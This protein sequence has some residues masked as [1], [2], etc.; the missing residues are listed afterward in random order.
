MLINKTRATAL[1]DFLQ[2]RR[3]ANLQSLLAR[4]S[5]RSIDLLNYEDVRRALKV[6]TRVDRGLQEIELDAIIGS[7]GRY[8]DF[9]RTFLPRSDSSKERWATVRQIATDGEGWPPIAV[10]QVG[11]AY[12]V[13]DGNHRVSV[14]RALGMKSIQA[15]VTEALT[16]IPL[17]PDV[18]PDDLI[19]KARYADFLQRTNLDQL[20]PQ[21]DLS[22]TAPGAYRILDEHIAI[23]HYYLG[24]N[25]Q[26][27]IPYA[28]AVA[29][30]YDHIYIPIIEVVRG[31]DILRDFPQ[32]T[33][34]DLYIWL[35]RHRADLQAELAWEI[36]TE[37]AATDLLGQQQEGGLARLGEKLITSVLPQG[38]QV[39]P[40]PGEW[41]KQQLARRYTG[42]LF[43]NILVPVN[44]AE[45]GWCGLEQAMIIAR[46]EES[47]LRGLHIVPTTAAQE[48]AEAT[49]VQTQFAQRCQENGI[50]G[51]LILENG[52]VPRLICDRARWNDLIVVN[53]TYPP[54]KA[55][56]A[57]LGSGFHQLVQRCPRPILA[58]PH[59]F[60]PLNRALLAYDGSPKAEEA[61]FL[62][63][64]LAER[65]QIELVVVMAQ[66]KNPVSAS[67]QQHARDYL[68]LH[69]VTATMIVAAG[70]AAKVIQ[71]TAVAY[72]CD[73]MII[74]GYGA[75]PVV[76]VVLGSTA[77]DILRRTNMPVLIC[78]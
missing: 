74:G 12:F 43:A 20:R 45:D 9:T 3:Q 17:S 77:N 18:Q 2:A 63:T 29:S 11:D 50:Q 1:E 25:Q 68:E 62:A 44:G 27:D 10:Y 7:V 54:G 65:W 13:L 67:S 59:T 24:L 16:H 4:M 31:R 14:A 8:T 39:G 60:S 26:R 40:E 72:G 5:G 76:E 61:L 69:E 49:A 15:Y 47:V 46:R 37:D 64:Y 48:G 56:L 52:P 42:N 33:E 51:S 73:F 36:T 66:D 19:I 58:V 71:E 70:N 53:L 55:M 57:R 34:T 22:V 6:T 35:S 78:Q 75:Q 38:L 21:A 32:R 41:R 30:W 28:E 23:H